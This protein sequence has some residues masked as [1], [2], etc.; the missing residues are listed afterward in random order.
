MLVL[1]LTTFLQKER[2]SQL[3]RVNSEQLTEL[4]RRNFISSICITRWDVFRS[5]IILVIVNMIIQSRLYY[6]GKN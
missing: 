1:I 5:D 4:L 6:T 3:F 2:Y